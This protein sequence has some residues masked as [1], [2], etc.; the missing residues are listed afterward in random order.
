MASVMIQGDDGKI[1]VHV[2]YSIMSGEVWHFSVG[3][4]VFV[5]Q[6]SG[7]LRP[8]WKRALARQALRRPHIDFGNFAFWTDEL[9]ELVDRLRLDAS[10]R[11][12]PPCGPASD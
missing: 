1:A 9:A 12:L 8:G 3:K 10:P 4:I 5:D 7:I 11:I 6:E 2:W